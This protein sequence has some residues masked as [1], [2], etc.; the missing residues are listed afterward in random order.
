[1]ACA[2]HTF[3]PPGKIITLLRK[4]GDFNLQLSSHPDSEGGIPDDW[5]FEEIF[6]VTRELVG[7]DHDLLG[8]L[9]SLDTR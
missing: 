7:N 1:M 5:I 3:G 8:W 4:R 9:H 6:G 2:N